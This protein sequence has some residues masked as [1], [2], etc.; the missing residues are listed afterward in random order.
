MSD[1]A[2]KPRWERK[3]NSNCDST[4]DDLRG[5]S[6]ELEGLEANLDD[7]RAMLRSALEDLPK[8]VIV[9]GTDGEL[10]YAN[11]AAEKLLGA[12]RE[13]D[14]GE[15]RT[16]YPNGDPDDPR[17]I[18]EQ[19]GMATCLEEERPVEPHAIEVEQFDGES[20]V[21]LG[22]SAPFYDADDELRGAIAVFTDVTEFKHLEEAQRKARKMA[23]QAADRMARLQEVTS[24]LFDALTPQE[25]VEVAVDHARRLPEA[26]RAAGCLFTDEE[27]LELIDDANYTAHFDGY[28]PVHIDDPVPV[29]ES[30]RLGT[31]IFLSDREEFAQRYPNLADRQDLT[32]SRAV[33]T[34]P[35]TAHSE[36]LGSL[37]LG[38]DEPRTFD[39]HD[40]AFLQTLASQCAQAVHRAQLY[41][42]EQKAR[43]EAEAAHQRTRFLSES[44]AILNSTLDYDDILRQ[45]AHLAVPEFADWCCVDLK[46]PEYDF[47]E[48]VALVHINPAKLE[49]AREARRNYP[50]GPDDGAREVIRTGEPRLVEDVSEE[51]LRARARDEQHL[52]FQR[53]MQIESL[54]VVPMAVRERTLGAI[55]FVSSSPH[56]LFDDKDLDTAE[57]LA[58]RAAMAVE[59]AELH[60]KTRRA[61]E[62]VSRRADQQEAVAR[63]ARRALE[64]D[65]ETLFEEAL[66]TLVDVLDANT[67]KL[68]EYRE[69]STLEL[70]AGVGWREEWMGTNLGPVDDETAI[71]HALLENEVVVVE[72]LSRSELGPTDLVTAHDLTSTM[73][74]QV[75]G[76]RRP[77]GA[78]GVHSRQPRTFTD[79]DSEFIRGV[80]NLLSDAIDKD[81]ARRQREATYRRLGEAMRDRE[82]LLS[83]VSHDLRSPATSVKM[84]LG[85]V[86]RQL[87]DVEADAETLEAIH[88]SL[89]VADGSIDRMVDMMTD[90]LEVARDDSDHDV[91]REPVDFQDA[92]DDVLGRLEGELAESSSRLDLHVGDQARGHSDRV[93]FEQIAANLI[94]NAIKYGDGQPIEVTLDTN[95]DIRLVVRDQGI[96]IAPEHQDNIFERF[97]RVEGEDDSDSFGLG[98]WIVKRSVD[99]LGGTIDFETEPSEGTEFRVRLPLEPDVD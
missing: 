62:R 7:E 14:S 47:R 16:S 12:R 35:L 19:W 57:E 11:P 69:D 60:R 99:A 4:R 30:V 55:T 58:S 42:D 54:M 79:E 38:F 52:E 98:L 80:S 15:N 93:R 17:F 20:A 64:A 32:P 10:T 33:A 34:V 21:I 8:G 26:D 76:P 75:P 66:E 48:P 29:A 92:L 87:E 84:N 23:E 28:R 46:G 88:R 45:I 73:T 63:L 41:R 27:T 24:E 59:R 72:D 71:G 39:E 43:A 13:A 1:D 89:D 5:V 95:D 91:T 36:A 82:E 49:M 83:V 2:T 94:S 25:A 78:I 40:R 97:H 18:P 6:R 56:D 96:G 53:R 70:R 65:L 9:C 44:T 81:R 74:V 90:L 51:F 68:V 3:T 37:V 31:G 77:F 50:P 85:L 86:R 67:A 22:C 61:H